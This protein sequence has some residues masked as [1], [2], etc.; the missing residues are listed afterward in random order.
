MIQ[1]RASNKVLLR[2]TIDKIS[3]R[4]PV[5][6]TNS[7]YRAA[8]SEIPHSHIAIL[9]KRCI[10]CT[11]FIWE[12]IIPHKCIR[13]ILFILQM[14]TISIEHIAECSFSRTILFV[15]RHGSL[16]RQNPFLRVHLCLHARQFDV[17]FLYRHHFQ[18]LL[19]YIEQQREL[20]T[21]SE[22]MKKLFVFATL[23][24][25]EAKINSAS[26]GIRK[27]WHLNIC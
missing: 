5:V 10:L 25:R 14:E 16:R 7:A 24:L 1:H 4:W 8:R 19:L 17:S 21:K 27:K 12:W 6:S 23:C 18:P 15:L 2:G 20:I 3:R 11:I 22:L 9:I 13:I 26:V